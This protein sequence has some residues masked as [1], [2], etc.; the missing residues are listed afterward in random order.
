MRY[1]VTGA[2]GLVGNNVVRLLLAAGHEVAVLARTTSDPR[3]L[4]GL[5][6]RKVPGDV[7]DAASVAAAC[8][9]ID[10]VI[11]AAGHVHIGWTEQ[12]VHHAIN[13]EG[14]RNI[15]VGA[16]EAGAKLVHVSSVN[17]LGLGPLDS[18]ADEDSAL[19]GIVPVPY[20]TTKQA[21]ERIVMDEVSRGLSGAIVNPATM[22]GPW[23]WKPSS[24]K[25]L[26]EVSK[27]SLFAPVGAGSF[28]DARDVAAGVI[29][30]GQRGQNG[31]R[32]IL[33]GRNLKFR[34]LWR[35]I[36]ALAGKPGPWVP[37]GP[38]FRAIAGPVCDIRTR[39]SGRET[40]ANSAAL[41]MSR[42]SHCFQSDRAKSELG[43]EFRPLDETL[44]DAWE[45]LGE[46]GFRQSAA[47][48][49]TVPGA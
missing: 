34:D 24:G 33:A 10:V 8:Q 29:A 45:W 47:S 46:Y 43:Y 13:V 39:L 18:P 2:T 27:G 36:A 9:G 5:D 12:D 35:Q 3:P 7:R 40:A 37:M 14:T 1:L 25:M 19:P 26:L 38:I 11:H 28:C 30:A 32:Y 6:V 23:D 20:V 15:A 48:P 17:A 21:A 4:A 44:R 49:L 16:R 41:A 42:Q 31:R 22:F